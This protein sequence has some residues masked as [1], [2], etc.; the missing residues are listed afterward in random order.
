[1][2]PL[3]NKKPSRSDILERQDN[4]CANCGIDF[5]ADDIPRFRYLIPLAYGGQE[6]ED[7]IEAVCTRCFEES[8]SDAADQ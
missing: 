8:G 2:P 4:S 1:M 6:S 7:N 5:S 3:D